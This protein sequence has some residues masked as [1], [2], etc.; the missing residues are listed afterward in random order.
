MA[1]DAYLYFPSAAASGNCPRP[2]GES[3]I[4]N[5]SGHNGAISLGEQWG[6]SL[7]N[8]LD[9]SAV[10]TG[11][12]AG[13]AEFQEFTIK[14]QVDA[15]SAVLFLACGCGA[16]FNKVLLVCRKATG[17]T[18]ASAQEIFLQWTFNMMVVEK[19]EWAYADPAPEETV[20]FKFGACEVQYF[21]QTS[22]DGTLTKKPPQQ[23]SQVKASNTLAVT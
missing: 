2:E 6:F 4:G 16:N 9:I 1:F 20:T 3:L 15:A 10:T 7:E 8:K 12:G 19:I 14:K 11:A 17:Q 23:W 5:A 21:Q 18:N 13:K 22:T